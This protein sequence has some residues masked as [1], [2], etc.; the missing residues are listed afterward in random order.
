MQQIYQNQSKPE[1]IDLQDFLKPEI[2]RFETISDRNFLLGANVARD[3]RGVDP[4]SP[5]LQLR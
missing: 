3:G 4:R 1:M 5:S 2:T